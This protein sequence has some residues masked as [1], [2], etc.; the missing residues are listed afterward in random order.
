MEIILKH[1]NKGQW[2]GVTKYKGCF[3]YISPLLTR[4]GAKHTGLTESDEER[5][6]KELGMEK[7]SLSKHSKFWDT[8]AVK[9]GAKELTLYT[10]RAWDELQYLFL[11]NHKHV[12]N[13]VND[14][15]ASS[16]YV[17]IN[18]DIEAVESNRINKRRRAAIKEFD[19]LSIDD[20]R[21]CLRVYGYKP[22]S[23]SNDLVESKL[24][25]NVEKDPDRFFLKWVDNKT[26]ETEFLIQTAVSKNIM[27][28]NKNVYYYG[29]DAIGTSLEDTI[30]YLDN[31][32]NQDLKISIM[33]EVENKK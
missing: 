8:F 14:I 19:K 4:S 17:L 30:S 20:M 26:K 27:R 10:D 29:T 31:K 25:E 15:K 21:K 2:S 22:E 32:A 9:L 16:K 6:E 28:R 11:R 1:K 3:D 24:F 18:G 12:S 23:M 33:S 7:G 5:L 13:G